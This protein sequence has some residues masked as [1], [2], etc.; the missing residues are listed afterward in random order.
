[1]C[2]IIINHIFIHLASGFYVIFARK[3]MYWLY[4]YTRELTCG[5]LK[6]DTTVTLTRFNVLGLLIIEATNSNST[7][8]EK[9]YI[10]LC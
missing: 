9:N 5:F 6:T 4:D 2:D 1:M 10:L 3:N 7:M 8:S